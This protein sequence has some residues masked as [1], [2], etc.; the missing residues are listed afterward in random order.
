MNVLTVFSFIFFTGLVAVISYFL[1]R[2]EKLDTQDGYFLGGRSLGAWVI[3]GS[4]LLTNLSTEQ[5]VGLNADGYKFNMSVMGWEVGSSIA[6]V[7]VAFFLLPRYLKG[8]IT[9]IPDFLEKR[10]D[11][12]TKQIVTLLFLFG[13][14]LNLLPPILYSGATALSSIF[15]VQEVFG[16]SYE[17]SIWIMVWAIGIIGSIY[18]IF[19]GLK[20]VAVSD[21]I[22]GIGLLIGGLLI[23]F[24][25]LT[26]LGDGSPIAG[27]QSIAENT[28]EKLNSIG[29][30]TDPV[31]FSTMFTG[32]LLVN[33]FYW[34]TAQHIIQRALAAKNLKEGQKGLVITAFLKL[35][36]PAFLILP[37]I[38]AYNIFGPGLEPMEAYPKLVN[39][40]LPTP[41]VGF[42]A[43][44]LF[45]AILSS[46][47]SALN[48]S[49]TLFALNIYKPFIRPNATDAQVVKNGK[50]VGTF[51]AIFAMCVAPLIMFVPQGF[52]QYLQI[53]NGFYNVPIL[54]IIIVGYATKRVPAIAAKISL[55]LF[56]SVYAITQLVWDTGIHFLHILAVLFVLCVGLMLLIGKIWPKD[57]VYELE[58]Q[59]VVDMTPWKLL[60]P[61]G[62]AAVVAM[63]TVYVL[64]SSAGFA[65]G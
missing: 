17:T 10:F 41:L 37:G 36:G 28:P 13:Y 38:I 44:V 59:K 43:A 56:I 21:T 47:N 33:L 53:V 35:L 20:A 7:L 29:S 27:F 46:F 63:I 39:H 2:D 49:V 9:T 1:T 55:A 25:G 14:V 64:F 18:A 52:F 3:A 57:T 24:L 4:L 15:N 19:G 45:G 34:G 8:G 40:V 62:F 11:S 22:N 23:P 12:G 61:M 31:P 16:V 30:N 32:M 54:T 65:N 6:L 26:M 42:F 50:I 60:Y 58:D 48:S 5:L 51:L